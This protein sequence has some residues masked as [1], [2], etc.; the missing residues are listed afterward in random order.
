VEP[1]KEFIQ[2]DGFVHNPS[3]YSNPMIQSS[4]NPE[5]PIKYGCSHDVQV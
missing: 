5:L 4:H 1:G 2:P 3:M